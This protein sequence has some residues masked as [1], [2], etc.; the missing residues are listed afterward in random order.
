MNYISSHFFISGSSLSSELLSAFLFT[1]GSA[2]TDRS[3]MKAS[4]DEKFESI[5]GK[6]PRFLE[7]WFLLNCERDLFWRGWCLW[8][9]GLVLGYTGKVA[10]EETSTIVLLYTSE[11]PMLWQSPDWPLSLYCLCLYI[12]LTSLSLCIITWLAS[13]SLYNYLTWD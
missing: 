7:D 8:S 5:F 12:Y 10:K 11:L 4:K 6:R 3:I 2:V 9:S 1:P 13:V